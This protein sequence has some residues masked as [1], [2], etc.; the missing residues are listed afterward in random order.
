[1]AATLE[2]DAGIVV[3]GV[4]V[5]GVLTSVVDDVPVTDPEA[6]EVL[7]GNVVLVGSVVGFPVIGVT[8]VELVPFPGLLDAGCVV[9]LPPLE[10]LQSTGDFGKLVLSPGL[11]MPAVDNPALLEVDQVQHGSPSSIRAVQSNLVKGFLFQYAQCY[12]IY[13]VH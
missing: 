11:V 5:E 2:P 1:V 10:D 8:E 13:L 3:F 6:I 7:V 12:Y 4:A 9:L